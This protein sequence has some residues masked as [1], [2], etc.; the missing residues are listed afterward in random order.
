MNE[1]G[2]EFQDISSETDICQN[3]STILFSQNNQDFIQV[4]PSKLFLLDSNLC[5]SRKHSLETG[6]ITYACWDPKSRSL[7]AAVDFVSDLRFVSIS[8]E[9]FSVHVFCSLEAEISSMT[10]HE[11]ETQTLVVFGSFQSRMW[12]FLVDSKL[13]I[14]HQQVFD[15]SSISSSSEN[16]VPESILVVESV[17]L[18]GLRNGTLILCNLGTEHVL[19]RFRVFPLGI[20]PI[21]L[22]QS[23]AGVLILTESSF[24][25]VSS[26]NNLSI[27]PVSCSP[28]TSRL[29]IAQ[30]LMD[31]SSFIGMDDDLNLR[32]FSITDCFRFGRSIPLHFSRDPVYL[33]SAGRKLTCLGQESLVCLNVNRSILDKFSSCAQLID[34]KGDERTF[35]RSDEEFV[36]C[37]CVWRTLEKEI[38]LF[39]LARDVNSATMMPRRMDSAGKIYAF[40]SSDLLN[41]AGQAL[42]GPCL[43]IC[44]FS[45][46]LFLVSCGAFVLAFT[47]KDLDSPLQFFR[48]LDSSPALSH[49]QMILSILSNDHKNVLIRVVNHGISLT[50]WLPDSKELKIVARE[51]RKTN[52]TAVALSNSVALASH[53]CGDVF[54]FSLSLASTQDGFWSPMAIIETKSYISSI[55]MLSGLENV[56]LMTTLCGSVRMLFPIDQIKCK[57]LLLVQA[58]LSKQC[59]S[60]SFVSVEEILKFISLDS[61][62]QSIIL[63]RV[64]Q[65]FPELSKRELVG[66]IDSFLH[67][68]NSLLLPS[69]ES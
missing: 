19:S 22:S 52:Y 56:W 6:T 38:V 51:E 46:E 34:S 33:D 10:L 47:C 53:A 13:E 66:L 36:S 3:A 44:P 32:I 21:F 54:V 17:V 28:E 69:I 67:D 57:P 8:L 23:Q 58:F 64:I 65:E 59:P 24:L 4:T 35:I 62:R 39:G 20:S 68:W 5:I 45:A 26:N 16:Q 9:S 41:Q 43:A 25:G 12:T 18:I 2:L 14:I 40:D 30:E 15:L 37:V 50:E 60:S 31:S 49:C 63:G 7:F 61:E 1:T 55:K 27:F 29:V 11:M 48:V 42:E